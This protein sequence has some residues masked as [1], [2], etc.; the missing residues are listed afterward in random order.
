ME[1]DITRPHQSKIKS[2][3]MSEFNLMSLFG[4]PMETEGKG[5]VVVP[6]HGSNLK[7][8]EVI[9]S[10]IRFIPFDRFDCLVFVY[11]NYNASE[12]FDLGGCRIFHK[13]GDW[14]RFQS[15]IE[16]WAVKEAGYTTVTLMLDDVLIAPP[17]MI[18]DGYETGPFREGFTLDRAY[19][20]LVAYDLSAA[21]PNVF[22]SDKATM[23]SGLGPVI[24]T[25]QPPKIT[26]KHHPKGFHSVGY[27]E[28]Q[29]IMFRMVDSGWPC[30]HTMLDPELNPIGWGVDICYKAFCNATLG[31]MDAAAIHL[32]RPSVFG[33]LQGTITTAFDKAEEQMREWAA[34]RTMNY[35]HLSDWPKGGRE[36]LKR[37]ARIG[38]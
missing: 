16:P 15:M 9:R 4:P 10:N 2:D 38:S 20:L 27:N 29:I 7:R 21:S 37:C 35:P 3:E 26:V 19:D 17:S 34:N 33:N 14:V 18:A 5:L 30:Y 25:S 36:I 28:I 12:N 31:L 32:G 8:R 6:G 13:K 24:S 23:T 1:R 22:A 11:A